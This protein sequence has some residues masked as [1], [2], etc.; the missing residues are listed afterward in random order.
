MNVDRGSIDRILALDDKTLSEL[1]QSIAQVSG[2]QGRRTQKLVNDVG[3]LREK[4]ARI[5]VRD[6]QRLV[7]AAGE[8]KSGEIA[9]LLRERGVD[10]G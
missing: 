9:R 1:A 2:A 7:E 3:F 4:L 5:S 8:E 10:L 6:A